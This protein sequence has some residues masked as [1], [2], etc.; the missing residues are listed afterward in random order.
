[1]SR[2][3]LGLIVLAITTC[4]NAESNLLLV[5]I[6]DTEFDG[7]FGTRFVAKDTAYP[8]SLVCFDADLR[9]EFPDVEWFENNEGELK[10]KTCFDQGMLENGPDDY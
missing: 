3:S 4:A 8:V 9:T 7:L 10:M 2:L 1:M 6:T 5:E